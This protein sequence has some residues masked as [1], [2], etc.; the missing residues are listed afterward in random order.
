MS[1]KKAAT[2]KNKVLAALPEAEYRPLLSGLEEIALPQNQVLYHAN[3]TFDYV[4]FPTSGMISLVSLT[5]DGATMEVGIIGY[6]GLLGVELFLESNRTPY[7][8]QVQV[9]GDGLRL[10]A[11]T[12]NS[13]WKQSDTLQSILRRY[14][15]I[16]MTQ[17][18]QATV[19][20]RFHTLTER[21]SRWLLQTQDLVR[22]DSFYLTQQFLAQM[23]GVRHT[24]ISVAAAT[25]Q[26]AGFISYSRGNIKILNR[27]GLESASCECYK[28]IHNATEKDIGT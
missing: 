28:I 5:E 17:L 24:G 6:T 16:M 22:S 1:E 4:Y 14:T 15:H 18:I 21:L 25:L 12:F 11:E 10:K 20:H 9:E 23:L 19:C 2:V 26:K 7:E 27:E 8:V 13:H 3:D